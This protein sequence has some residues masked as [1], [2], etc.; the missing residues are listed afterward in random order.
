[1]HDWVVVLI[2][3]VF[4]LLPVP[5]LL[6]MALVKIGNAKARIDTLEREVRGLQLAMHDVNKTPAAA[7]S[8]AQS[9]I[10]QTAVS[11]SEMAETQT[12]APEAHI[13][14][15]EGREKSE[16]PPLPW[17]RP[18]VVGA[19]SIGATAAQEQDRQQARAS[20]PPTQPPPSVRPPPARPP[21]RPP[22]PP[23]PPADPFGPALRWVKGWFT[24]GNVPVKIGMLVLLAG[25]AALLKYAADQGWVHVPMEFRLSGIAV[26]AMGGLV[27]AWRQRAQRRPFAL[28]LQGGAIGVL[29]LVV[30]AAFKLY[31]LLPAGAAFAIT[32]ALVAGLGVLAV[33]QD[34][35]ALAV[36]GIL[37]GFLAPIWLST[38]S[39][40]HVALF[41]YYAV[42]NVAI[43]G[44]AWAQSKGRGPWRVLNLLGFV[45]TFGIGTLWGVLKYS[46]DKFA[47]TE[48]FLLLF[49]ALYLLIPIFYARGREALGRVVDQVTNQDRPVES[50][51]VESRLVESRYVDSTLV[52]GT[53]LVSFALQ[54]GLL[55][56]EFTH[57][58]RMPLAFSALGLAAIYALLGVL[59]QRRDRFRSLIEAYAVLAVGFATLA[60]PLALSAHATASV[61]ALEGA[62]L[63]WLG[64]RQQR[65]LPQLTGLLLQLAAAVAY[66]TGASE[67]DAISLF[68]G[69][70]SVDPNAIMPISALPDVIMPIANAAFMGAMLI[71]LA[72]FAI[73]WSYRRSLDRVLVGLLTV[74]AIGWW[75]F[76]G[77][78]EIAR[79]VASQL[80][81]DSWFAFVVFSGWLAAEARR[82]VHDLPVLGGLAATALLL[83][84]P[85]AIAQSAEH[86]QPFAYWGWAAWV[87][88]AVLGWRSLICLRDAGTAIRGFAHAGWWWSWTIASL[89]VLHELVQSS[90][91]G[92]GWLATA[93]GL[94]LL[95]LAGVM[96]L[97]PMLLAAPLADGFDAYRKP[98]LMS[99]QS[100]LALFWAISLLFPGDSTPLPWVALLNPLELLQ[101]AAL[102]LLAWWAWKSGDHRVVSARA[103]VPLFAFAAFVWITFATLRASH[104]WAG[105]DWSP[106]MLGNT[107]V[108]TALTV[109]WSVLG[110][111]G[112]IFGSRRGD[113]LL[114]G[115]GA[116]LMAVVLLKLVLIDRTHLGNIFGIVSFLA[117]GLLCTAV[118]Y[119]APAPPRRTHAEI[120][121]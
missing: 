120:A 94:P 110:V 22:L 4:L 56:D 53:P 65:W 45:F 13:A 10:A 24:E 35:L 19:I 103:R 61:F 25:V 90:S 63:V 47:T 86:A 17:E 72:G 57:G 106:L 85:L 38:G 95:T 21:P 3:V 59:L 30:F 80:R 7:A 108:Q 14:S 62:G 2:L 83:G 121:S 109:V 88:F 67:S 60:V 42:L 102:A 98:W 78:Q 5:L 6:V 74:W 46:P 12:T 71:A 32:I 43:F 66:V 29:M 75:G 16:P 69:S 76:A 115:A 26:A 89:C 77:T 112:W 52:F 28:A 105:T 54:A 118:G 49:F 58:S 96:Q 82:R 51:L 99:A 91:L 34:A 33:L 70:V 68:T 113:R 15:D 117:Y 93:I 55:H 50:R 23:L 64:L 1:M 11:I 40:N 107:E 73:A 81:V 37:A 36:F 8:F 18:S 39:G 41:G 44:I 31:G 27:F 84:I 100:V 9:P 20:L 92:N 111:L 116:A 114:W 97:R 79:H 119:F 87:L 48:P 104:H 101:M